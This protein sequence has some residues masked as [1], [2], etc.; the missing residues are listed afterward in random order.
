MPI[1]TKTPQ[2]RLALRGFTRQFYAWHETT[3]TVKESKPTLS[4]AYPGVVEL[5]RSRIFT[6]HNTKED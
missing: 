6:Q 1:C 4:R 2:F 3:R 5:I